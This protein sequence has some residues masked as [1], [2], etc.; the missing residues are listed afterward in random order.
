M[1]TVTRLLKIIISIGRKKRISLLAAGLAFHMFI[2]II[3]L[4]ILTL[5]IGNQL[6]GEIFANQVIEI[7]KNILPQ[8]GEKFIISTLTN[9]ADYK[10]LTVIGFLVL[11]W[12]GIRVFRGLDLAF[13]EIYGSRP[14]SIFK[15]ITKALLAM[16]LLSIGIVLIV[17]IEIFIALTP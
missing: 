10:G 15:E 11:F 8:I 2:S 17:L 12:A 14:K 6:G 13:S 4:L 7:T 3:P 5:I 9:S 16:A 1:K